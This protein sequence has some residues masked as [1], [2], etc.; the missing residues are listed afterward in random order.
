MYIFKKIYK[1]ITY[2]VD[3]SNEYLRLVVS[4]YTSLSYGREILTT[5]DR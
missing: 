4:W 2:N 3:G 5:V 1:Y